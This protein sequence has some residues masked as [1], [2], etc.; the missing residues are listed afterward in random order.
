MVGL[1]T[2]VF[3]R[4]GGRTCIG[5]GFDQCF[6]FVERGSHLGVVDPA[7]AWDESSDESRCFAGSS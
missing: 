3:L 4:R 2:H 1:S 6:S 7:R 5:A